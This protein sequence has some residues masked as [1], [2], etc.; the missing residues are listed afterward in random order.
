MRG[1]FYKTLIVLISLG[2]S[3]MAVK[4]STDKHELRAE[5]AANVTLRELLDEMV[6][7]MTEKQRQIDRLSQ[8]PCGSPNKTEQTTSK[9]DASGPANESLP[10][11]KSDQLPSPKNR[12]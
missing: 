11:R 3:V 7:G 5:T 2:G 8:S 10:G 4:W 1:I 9:H 6:I 12:T